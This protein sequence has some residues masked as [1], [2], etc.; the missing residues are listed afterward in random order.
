[1][2]S[3]RLQCMHLPEHLVAYLAGCGRALVNVL[4]VFPQTVGHIVALGAE[5]TAEAGVGRQLILFGGGGGRVI[6]G[7]VSS[8]AAREGGVGGAAR[9]RSLFWRVDSESRWC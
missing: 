9:R 6:P 4:H 2:K 8:H 1:M 3:S 7:Q 5:Q